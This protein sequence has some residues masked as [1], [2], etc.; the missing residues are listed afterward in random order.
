MNTHFQISAPHQA[1]GL[2]EVEII[3]AAAFQA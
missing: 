3:I 2:L 1:R